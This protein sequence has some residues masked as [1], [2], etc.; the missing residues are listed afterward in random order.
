[1]E[2]TRVFQ[3]LMLSRGPTAQGSS[4]WDL[5]TSASS[6]GFG[7]VC[8]YWVGLEFAGSAVEGLRFQGL[9]P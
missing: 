8:E 9:G 4:T 3:G 7:D 2:A 5:G 1:M 6:I